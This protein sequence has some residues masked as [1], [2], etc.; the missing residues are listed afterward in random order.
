MF[1][2]IVVGYYGIIDLVGKRDVIL[3][4]EEFDEES[5]G[6]KDGRSCW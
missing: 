3:Q 5:K 6:S 2:M 4:H 1:A